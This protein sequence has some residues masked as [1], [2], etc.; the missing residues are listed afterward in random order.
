[1]TYKGMVTLKQRY[2]ENPCGTLSTAYWKEDFFTKPNGIKIVHERSDNVAE[3][4]TRYFRLVHY[5]QKEYATVLPNGFVY[6]NAVLPNECAMV[7][8]F[9]NHCYAGSQISDNEVERWFNF[10]V[11][12]ENLWVWI[13]NETTDEPIALGIADYDAEISE[14][15]L[16][17]IQVL[18]D[19]QGMGFGL[20]IVNELLSR[21]KARVQFVTV[22]GEVDN[23]ANPERLYRKCGFAG[24]DIWIVSRNDG[25][26]M[27]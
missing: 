9:I 3:I 14:G 4:G 26:Q 2:I 25:G 24:S 10:P 22:S 17:W 19:K 23:P 15:S 12:D 6:R 8:D 7:A 13:C 20:A 21:L 5:P 16:E 1:M 18:S 11:F 27:L